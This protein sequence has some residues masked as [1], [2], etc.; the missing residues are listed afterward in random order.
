MKK[1][2]SKL[3]SLLLTFVMVLALMPTF[4]FATD[5]TA[6]AT[7][8]GDTTD[9]GKILLKQVTTALFHCISF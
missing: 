6:T 1:A 7:K 9:T 3:F 5:D 4:A 2:K 8:P